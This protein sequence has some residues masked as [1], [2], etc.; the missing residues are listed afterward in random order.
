M[1]KTIV[2]PATL[3]TKGEETEFLKREIEKKGHRT[4]L[5]DVGVLG[6]PQARAD[7]ARE[8]VAEAGGRPLGDLVRQAEQ[9]A[10]R[11]E[12]TNIMIKGLQRIVQDLYSDGRLDGIIS[13]GGSTGT[14]IGTSAMSVLPTGIPKFMVSTWFE[15]QFVGAKDITMMQAPADILGLNSVTRKTLA[16]AA[17][18]ISG[19][20]EIE[21]EKQDKPSVGITALGVTTPAAMKIKALLDK[22]GYDPI[23]FHSKTQVLDELVQDGRITG[24][25]DLTTFEVTVPLTYHLPMELAEN[26]LKLAGDKG[27]PQVIIPGGLDML[28]FTGTR[29]SV[30]SEYRNRILHAHGPDRVLA[31]TTKEE[32]A[33][34]ARVL[35]ERANRA[36]GPVRVVIPSQGFSAVDRAGQHFFDPAAD[37]F[38]ASVM[39]EHLTK[40]IEIVLVDAHINDEKFAKAVVEVY[41]S[42]CRNRV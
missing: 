26:R 11:T 32:V 14:A 15:L 18:A 35:A 12:A 39:R 19:M 28:I 8:Q 20:V 42:L 4:I 3:D 6:R 25:I 37:A 27:L 10:D 30:P 2:I 17:A 9:G 1:A 23:V 31:R 41:D 38:F 22:K 21:R 34:A 29:E 13:L 33:A 7:I 24:I 16:M 36:S 5:V 40:G